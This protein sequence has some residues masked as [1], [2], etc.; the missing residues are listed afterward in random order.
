M[1][2]G[3]DKGVKEALGKTAAFGPDV[4]I[5]KYEVGTKDVEQVKDLEKAP[6]T[7]KESTTA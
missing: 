6:E 1:Q 2:N 3:G 7:M 4:D 5:S